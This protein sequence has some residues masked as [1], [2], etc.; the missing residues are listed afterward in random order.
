MALNADFI[1]AVD[2]RNMPRVYRR[3]A[4][5]MP[6]DPSLQ[7]LDEMLEYAGRHQDL[8]QPH[9]GESLKHAESDWSRDYYDEQKLNLENNFSQERL[10]LMR[11]MTLHRYAEKIEARKKEKEEDEKSRGFNIKPR[12]IAGGCALVG[13]AAAVAYGA[14]AGSALLTGA[15][16]AFALGGVAILVLGPKFENVR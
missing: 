6:I 12:H 13:G 4:D 16:A 2:E 8:F 5:I 7:M 9:D 1:A 15:G 10:A 14:Y 11:K 3:L